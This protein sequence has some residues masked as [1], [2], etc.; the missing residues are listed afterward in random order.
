MTF[1]YIYIK[2]K[3]VIFSPL[4]NCS[5]ATGLIALEGD[6]ALVISLNLPANKELV[7][8]SGRSPLEE[9]TEGAKETGP[10]ASFRIGR[11]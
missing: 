3:L 4:L 5:F 8:F 9:Q 11:G 2:K 6:I 10:S 1:I 7:S